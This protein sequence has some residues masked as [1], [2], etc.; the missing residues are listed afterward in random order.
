MSTITTT[1]QSLFTPNGSPRFTIDELCL[2]VDA[3]RGR[4]VC[5]TQSAGSG[6]LPKQINGLTWTI[7]TEIDR[8]TLDDYW[9]VEAEELLP[10]IVGISI[11]LEN[12]LMVGLGRVPKD[13]AWSRSRQ[14]Q[15]LLEQVNG[16]VAGVEP[17]RG[18]S[19]LGPFL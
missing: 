10:K 6:D 13:R 12:A 7:Q 8:R 16:L 5:A 2:V 3:L 19:R 11:E 17:P 18:A 15:E 1:I 14:L 9:D 4:E